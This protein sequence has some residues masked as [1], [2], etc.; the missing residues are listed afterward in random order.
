MRLQ[1]EAELAKPTKQERQG[2]ALQAQ[3]RKKQRRPEDT[4]QIDIINMCKEWY[5][6]LLIDQR[7]SAE[8]RKSMLSDWIYHIPNGGGRSKAEGGI[9]KAMGVKA[10]VHDLFLMVPVATR[11]G[12]F[13]GAYFELKTDNNDLTDSQIKFGANARSMGYATYE[14]RTTSAFRD[15]IDG[16]FYEARPLI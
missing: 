14:T 3:A 6:Q 11:V 13:C 12:S 2:D 15:Q 9:F 1:I 16:Y 4:L 10:G 7:W 5:M 8:H